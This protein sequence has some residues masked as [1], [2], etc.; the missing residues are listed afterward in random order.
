MPLLA[1]TAVAS[2]AGLM[3]VAQAAEQC[4]CMIWVWFDPTRRDLCVCLCLCLCDDLTNCHYISYQ[5]IQI[6]PPH[7]SHQPVHVVHEP[8]H[9]IAV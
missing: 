6:Q 5:T 7:R 3:Q 4:E 8:V 1:A 2:L 9:V